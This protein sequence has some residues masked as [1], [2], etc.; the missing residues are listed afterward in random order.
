[1]RSLNVNPVTFESPRY[2]LMLFVA[3]MLVV[4]KLMRKRKMKR[5]RKK[6]K[7]RKRKM[8]LKVKPRHPNRNPYRAARKRKRKMKMNLM[9]TKVQKKQVLMVQHQGSLADRTNIFKQKM[10]TLNTLLLQPMVMSM[11]IFNPNGEQINIVMF[12]YSL[13]FSCFNK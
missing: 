3:V 10:N 1:M 6:K 4:Q 2:M 13:L 7:T 5:K 9:K 12:M 11:L 8:S